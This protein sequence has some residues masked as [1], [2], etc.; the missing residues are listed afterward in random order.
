ML[1]E[2]L[3]RHL[4]TARCRFVEPA[5]RLLLGN[6]AMLSLLWG[7]FPG[8]SC[9]LPCRDEP[10]AGGGSWVA[11][12]LFAREGSNVTVCRHGRVAEE[13]GGEFDDQKRVNQE[14]VESAALTG[15]RSRFGVWMAGRN[16][17][18]LAVRE[19]DGLIITGDSPFVPHAI[20]PS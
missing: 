1:R 12:P 13:T 19:T 20:E 9:L 4:P 15:F 6:K 8:H 17:V 14:F 3:A 18:A 10:P 5:R 11:K 7:L 2:P 16:P